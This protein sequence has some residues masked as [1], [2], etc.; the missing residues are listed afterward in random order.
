MFCFSNE[1]ASTPRHNVVVDACCESRLHTAGSFCYEEDGRDPGLSH[2][3]SPFH[4]RAVPGVGGGG[5]GVRSP[6]EVEC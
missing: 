5:V 1:V 2:H 3:K 6:P 4:F